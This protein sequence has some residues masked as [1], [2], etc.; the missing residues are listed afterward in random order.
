[1]RDYEKISAIILSGGLSSRMGQDK[2]DL[3][4][5]GETLLNI[6][7][8]KLKSIGI[9]DIIASGYRGINAKSKIVHDDIM[10]GPLSGIL[11]GLKEIK[12]D[13]AFVISVDVPL[14]RR[15]CI[16]KIID[17]SYEKDLE[18]AMIRHCGNCEPLMGVYTKSLIPRIEEILHGD[19]YSVMK[20]SDVARYDF[21]D[22]DDD[23]KYFLNVNNK[24]DYNTLL[25]IS[26]KGGIQ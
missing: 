9:T 13:R 18:M 8:D 7:I 1:M 10:K 19:S 21:L 11:L 3:K 6:Q 12:N 26:F 14:V 22:I 17:Y 4:F 5:D 20:L 16:K 15:T 24:N 23:D 2:C 25:K